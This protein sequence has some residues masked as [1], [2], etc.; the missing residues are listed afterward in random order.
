MSL[1]LDEYEC[2]RFVPTRRPKYCS[3]GHGQ[4]LERYDLSNRPG[5]TTH[6]LKGVKNWKTPRG[7]L[8]CPRSQSIDQKQAQLSTWP[9]GLDG[10]QADLGWGTTPPCLM[11]KD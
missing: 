7:S 8:S 3:Q 4:H 5:G 11:V 1:I 6:F 10:A 9:W 2:Q